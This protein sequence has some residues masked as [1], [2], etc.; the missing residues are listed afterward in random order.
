MKR[1]L[2]CISLFTIVSVFM[3]SILLTGINFPANEK[4]V[5]ASMT[6]YD[7]VEWEAPSI[8]NKTAIVKEAV[9]DSYSEEDIALL[10]AMN[11]D[12]TFFNISYEE[13]DTN[14]TDMP[15]VEVTSVITFT[16]E[17]NEIYEGVPEDSEVK[18]KT[19]DITSFSSEEN[20]IYE[21]VPVE[22]EEEIIPEEIVIEEPII[23]EDLPFT[24]ANC[25]ARYESETIDHSVKI[26]ENEELS[27]DLQNFAQTCCNMADPQVPIEVFIALMDQES[28]Y[29]P[30]AVGEDGHDIGLCQV[31]DSNFNKITKET[32]VNYYTDAK[33]NIVAG[34]YML[35]D[36]MN[37]YPNDSFHLILMVYN[38]GPSYAQRQI[39]RGNYSSNY[40]RLI[41]SHAEEL[42]Y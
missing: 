1:K 22:P 7:S 15:T 11:T 29:D 32:G 8:I 41:M 40:S 35:S 4:T 17:K 18:D 16:Y 26:F 24:Y 20:D 28:V 14:V 42:G 31:R 36:A 3:I 6:N 21:G 23:L 19:H 37:Y 39:N 12:P 10:T 33:Q 30:S 27:A 9:E 5:A 25:I 34:V 2:S 38:G 13:S